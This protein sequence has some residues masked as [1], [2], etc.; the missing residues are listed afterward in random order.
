[1][2][3]NG[4]SLEDCYSNVYALT[5]LNGLKWRC[6][7]T[8]SNSPRGIPIQSDP[9]L[10]AYGRCLRD[11]LLCTWRRKPLQM[12]SQP[13][14]LP[15]PSFTNEIAKELWIFWYTNEPPEKLSVNTSHLDTDENG[16]GCAANGINYE[17]RVL[18]FQALHTMIER[19]MAH[20]G[21]VRFGRWFTRPL[22]EPLFGR[23]H[24]LP[25]YIMATNVQFFV[26]GGNTV[27]MTV[28]AQRQ[29]PLLRLCK[30]HVESGHRVQVVVGP[31]SLRAVL[32]PADT[33][34]GRN[35]S[36]AEKQWEEWKEFVASL[37]ENVDD[38]DEESREKGVPR[39][40]P[41]EIDGIR[42]LYPSCYVCVTME[43]DASCSKDEQPAPAM[44][45][46]ELITTDNGRRNQLL[47]SNVNGHSYMQGVL[48]NS[49]LVASRPQPSPIPPPQAG[50]FQAP[51]P[52]HS[53]DDTRW[54]FVD[55]SKNDSCAC[56]I[57][58]H[59][60]S[61]EYWAALEREPV[62]DCPLA[63]PIK[64][65]SRPGLF[66]T[67]PL[68]KA[69][70]RQ[71]KKRAKHSYHR[72]FPLK[73]DSSGVGASS[74][75]SMGSEQDSSDDENVNTPIWAD[76]NKQSLVTGIYCSADDASYHFG[77]TTPCNSS[78]DENLACSPFTPIR[79]VSPCTNCTWPSAPAGQIPESVFNQIF[80][81]SSTSRVPPT[82]SQEER[83]R[84][85]NCYY[86]P[87][88]REDPY[89]MSYHSRRAG[90]KRRSSYPPSI[91]I[92][93]SPE[94]PGSQET[95]P[96]TTSPLNE[97]DDQR[98]RVPEADPS[99]TMTRAVTE[100]DLKRP[101][102]QVHSRRKLKKSKRLV[103][104]PDLDSLD[105]ALL[106][107]TIGEEMEARVSP[108]VGRISPTCSTEAD[109]DVEERISSPDGNE[110]RAIGEG[111]SGMKYSPGYVLHNVLGACIESMEVDEPTVCGPTDTIN[112]LSPPASNERPE[113]NAVT[114]LN[115]G[116]WP[117]IGGPPS[118]GDP[119]MNH[120]YPTPP[121]VQS[122]A[123][124][125]SPAPMLPPQQQ[126]A[127]QYQHTNISQMQHMSNIDTA[128]YT[129]SAS[130][131]YNTHHPLAQATTLSKFETKEM[132]DDIA[133]DFDDCEENT[134][135][136]V[137]LKSTMGQLLMRV[138][139][140][141]VSGHVRKK[142]VPVSSRFSP[143][144]DVRLLRTNL[145]SRKE[146]L[147]MPPDYQKLIQH[148]KKRV[149][150]TVDS[151]FSTQFSS[152]ITSVAPSHI[153]S[154]T[155]TSFPNTSNY[156]PTFGP[157]SGLTPNSHMQIPPL[158]PLQSHHMQQF[159]ASQIR[160]PPMMGARMGTPVVA[161]PM[162]PPYA[163]TSAPYGSM[164]A[165]P[166][167]VQQLNNFVHGSMFNSPASGQMNPHHMGGMPMGQPMGQ[168]MY[169]TGP[170]QMSMISPC[171]TAGYGGPPMMG[172]YGP[173]AP[174]IIGPPHASAPPAYPG[175]HVPSAYVPMNPIQPMQ[176]PHM[177]QM[178]KMQ[179]MMPAQVQMPI[180]NSF[181]SNTSASSNGNMQLTASQ[182]REVVLPYAEGS[183][184]VLAIVLQDTILDLHF[185]SVFDA[186][187]ICSCNTSIRARELGLYITPPDV[188]R[189][190]AHLQQA[191][192]GSWSGFALE[193]ANV[194]TCGFSA[195]RHRYLSLCSGLFPEDSREATAI[196]HSVAPVNGLGAEVGLQ[197]SSQIWFD[198][199]SSTDVNMLDLLR[200]MCQQ[201][202]MGRMVHQIAH[203]VEQADK[204]IKAQEVSFDASSNSEY[205]LSQVDAT[206]L[207]LIG[208]SAAEMARISGNRS[209][210]T[211]QPILQFFHP[212]GL[213]VANEV[214]DPKEAEWRGLL[215]DI[216]PILERALRV[217]RCMHS[218]S[219]N[220][221]EGPLSWRA[222][223][224]KSQPKSCSPI[225]DDDISSPEPI[226]YINIAAEKDAIRAAPHVV[227]HW[228]HLSLGPIDQPKDVLYL[229][230]VPDSAEICTMA[231]KY[232]EQLSQMYERM[233]LGRH[234]A[235]PTGV[236]GRDGCV[237]VGC[238]TQSGKYPTETT[239]LDFLNLVG[240]Y[241]DNK[242]FM[243]KLRLFTQQMEENVLQ[244]VT[245]RDDLFER[246]AF[247]ETLALDWRAKRA[248]AAAIAL[249]VEQRL[250][251]SAAEQGGSVVP[252]EPPPTEPP[253][254]PEDV[255]VDDPGTLPHVIVI[256]VFNPFT[257][258]TEYRC[259]LFTRVATLA[260]MRAFNTVCLR[261]P[262]YRRTQL[263]LEIVPMEQVTDLLG[264]LPDYTNESGISQ[265]LL[266]NS[267]GNE[268]EQVDCVA[269]ESLRA[270]VLSV[271][272]QPRVLT[273]DC[274]KS[275]QA[276]CMT[277]FGPG[278][279][280]LD[281]LDEWERSGTTVFYK[282]PSNP[283]HLAPP[284]LLY[285]KY[286]NGRILQS[287]D[288]QVLYVTY[289]LAGS[290]WL[291]VTVTDS[292][293]RL[294]DNC[295]INLRTR[296]DHHI[297]KYRQ[298]TQILDAMGRLWTYILGILSMET[299]NW[300]LVIG[301]LGRIGHGE[302]R[303]WT[304]LLNKT[305][306]KRH[307][308][309]LKEVCTACAQMPGCTGTPSILSACLVST[310]PEPYLRMF[311]GFTCMDAYS[312][313]PRSAAPDDT[314]ITHIMVFPTSADI[315]LG[316][317]DQHAVGEDDWDFSDMDI[318]QDG[319]D[320]GDDFL[321]SI[322]MDNLGP[323]QQGTN[324][325][326]TGNSFFSENT[327]D[328]SM[329][330]QPLATGFYVS[331]APA[332]DVPD[333]F[334]TSCPSAKN[335]TP[336]HL[337]SSLHINVPL[338]HQGDEFL[339][340][341]AAAG[342]KQEKESAHALD[343]TRTDEVLRHVLETYNALSWLNIDVVSGERRSCLPIHMQALNRLYHSVARLIM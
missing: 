1:M 244:L 309:R 255:P 97:I 31:W 327:A 321:S 194:C 95:I 111:P 330:N 23:Q 217:V 307:S 228:E 233:R 214:R 172:G 198:S 167:S 199:T 118:C 119:S 204:A 338:V 179:Q 166:N 138:Q 308:A 239:T 302:F 17:V 98:R 134:N 170:G 342:D 319:N 209:R 9:I 151:L 110:T 117:R 324:F 36:S 269:V 176:S 234:I 115:Y 178:Q 19:S 154:V 59:Q 16:V 20:D 12:S 284:P 270:T 94:Q 336:V 80:Q 229:T 197:A 326:T 274:I 79:V 262:A 195:V 180:M 177:R 126:H 122:E 286:E 45:P 89:Y 84:D 285:Q 305:A 306:L 272:S 250:A 57:C 206:E 283:Y 238:R 240:R 215:S 65:A 295:L 32:L 275:V 249:A 317:T 153:T 335:R 248:S 67:N 24:L 124:Q 219:G 69:M 265:S 130:L 185:D 268:R 66:K 303:A 34:I 62:E 33:E 27:C 7:L 236:D 42:M 102:V 46:D 273:A 332:A 290:D 263:Q 264:C 146:S 149:P 218:V 325:R 208:N 26:H 253:L 257:W 53:D 35:Q 105:M 147:H 55:P 320:L 266:E 247:R 328:V 300:R 6:F 141:P 75:D 183:S 87:T 171:S 160:T 48:Q 316:S 252:P 70:K 221:V 93:V 129:T 148:M 318:P 224:N 73:P 28:N 242:A 4:G 44:T 340:G 245:E 132:K 187:P 200:I 254:E 343:S 60:P 116:G 210:S 103:E 142:L 292:L 120:I 205:V 54:S 22:R 207:M 61:A 114:S 72:R 304:Y 216:G 278:S 37:A 333:W 237:R 156:K 298:Q 29:P 40:V 173:P 174:N 109:Y 241:V 91:K 261:L 3:M 88:I 212:W 220:I 157:M 71:S 331:T 294:N 125:F 14:P 85:Y 161:G 86:N 101:D 181:A 76:T 10:K 38:I 312:K 96:A 2:A 58:T 258:G 243:T 164:M 74:S 78:D 30:R 280:L 106:S 25:R 143:A 297:Y 123:Q 41:I 213:Q 203:F 83:Q 291:C 15:L 21:F 18:L 131:Q 159:P 311:P 50:P 287:S 56:D 301:R 137:P 188:L 68:Y 5:E 184:V 51:F 108:C 259:A 90:E 11:G 225:L 189:M 182:S 193:Q 256:Y 64:V 322:C 277:K 341:K 8:P 135:D 323:P 293:G 165:P 139:L 133:E 230:V 162:G 190:P 276:R 136:L 232:M 145:T 155:V 152:S 329:E 313:K 192:I 47:V 175:A 127:V 49:F 227:R 271:Y 196:E 168:Q 314:S 296:H 191:Q 288:E 163:P 186:C 43:D 235:W 13:E 112:L 251:E 310:E 150:K 281:S 337:K 282:V 334:W 202:N 339:Q 77:V 81:P 39:M 104:W 315:Q 222:L 121:S 201:H 299:R 63:A 267:G 100:L 52:P 246:A 113:G 279:S 82:A 211:N 158:Q 223:T 128:V 226:P 107:T 169:A 260:V 99:I 92:P 289:C 231:V 140:L 144:V